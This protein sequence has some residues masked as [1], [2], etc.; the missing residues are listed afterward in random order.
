MHVLLIDTVLSA[1]GLLSQTTK[2]LSTAKPVCI[3]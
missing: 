2:D 3:P 1:T